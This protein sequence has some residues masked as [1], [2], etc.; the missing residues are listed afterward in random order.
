MKAKCI[1]LLCLTGLLVLTGGCLVVPAQQ[2]DSGYARTNVTKDTPSSFHSGASTKIDL[3][4]ELGE[5]DA[6]SSDERRFAYRAEKVV[7]YWI[8]FSS[9]SADAGSILRQ[10][11]LVLD[12]DSGGRFKSCASSKRFIPKTPE[13]FLATPAKDQPETLQRQDAP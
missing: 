8:V 6:A 12:F 3:L 2:H 5:P 10:H 1:P 9:T 7:G 11:F 4:L 13:K